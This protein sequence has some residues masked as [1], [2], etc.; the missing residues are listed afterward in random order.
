M[1][2]FSVLIAVLQ[3][4]AVAATAAPFVTV[5]FTNVA[6]GVATSSQGNLSLH[7]DDG[8]RVVPG[9]P[10]GTPY[11][12]LD[13]TAASD[14][15]VDS[16][17]AA[18]KLVGDEMAASFWFRPDRLANCQIAFGFTLLSEANNS[19]APFSFSLNTKENDFGVHKLWALIEGNVD[20]ATN[21]WHHAA[22]LYSISNDTF[23]VW[24]DG[25]PHRNSTIGT[26]E[27]SPVNNFLGL[28]IGRGFKGA[29]ADMR[30][31][32]YS[33]TP[34]EI[35]Q[36]DIS[37]AAR[38]ETADAFLY[39]ASASG[40][41]ASFRKW[42]T[43]MAA[44]A[45]GFAE[46]G[47]VREWMRLQDALWKL[48]E[49]G[50]LAATTS[51]PTLAETPF[52]PIGIYA[53]FEKKRLPFRMPEDGKTLNALAMR[54]ALGEIEGASFM[55]YPYES[56]QFFAEPTVLHGPG[57]ATIPASAIDIRTVKFW[58]S[59]ASGWL[60][61]FGGGKEKPVLTGEILLHDDAMLKVDREKH[62]NYL[63]LSYPDGVRYADMSTYGSAVGMEVFMIGA[64]PV[65]DAPS[66]VPMPFR[67]GDLSQMWITA[68][69]P[70]DATPGDYEGSLSFTLDGKPAG[71]LPLKLHVHPFRLPRA[72]PRYNIDQRLITTWF[73]HI[74]LGTKLSRGG[75]Y[76]GGNSL[77]NACRRLFAECKNMA[78]HNMY[79]PFTSCYASEETE[80]IQDLQFEI[81]SKAGLDLD[82]IMGGDLPSY[83][84]EWVVGMSR[85]RSEYDN[86][87]SV[88]D[89]PKLFAERM[90]AY[91]NQVR[92]GMAR[93][94]AR[95][96]NVT[97]YSYG[98]DEGS[99][100]T[101]RREM[102]FFATLQHFGGKAFISFGA[103]EW[104]SHMADLNDIAAHIARTEAHHWHEGGCKVGTYAAPFSGPESPE[105]WR[106]SMGI[107]V[108]MANYDAVS[109]YAWYEAWNVWNNFVVESRYGNFCIVYPTA[110]GVVDTVG[111]E[112]QREG[113]D[114]M[115]YLTLLRR[116][117]REAIRSR[118][119]E[120]R[121]H[122]RLAYA[123]AEMVDPSSDD[124]DVMR[125]EAARRIV[126]LRE[127]LKD[128]DT[129]ALYE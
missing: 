8:V 120:V 15:R 46:K 114:D 67:Q 126:A 100:D 5:D 4:A 9:G 22:F 102:P 85:R 24:I 36:T 101:V 47:D 37:P 21:K 54:G 10:T 42:C 92:N 73:H 20:T 96:G 63:R 121:R 83:D 50:R 77:S 97:L 31:W 27:P 71:S 103:D 59:H 94:R 127:V 129:E 2:Q 58:H 79:N 109:N 17:Q 69:I 38:K 12:Q 80:D 119:R 48:P 28:A 33:A 51:A 113:L 88:E 18:S 98:V 34:D 78:E 90:A 60:S 64:E 76:G 3:A 93:M 52:L 56:G 7:L 81:M 115:R 95:L 128:V 44:R 75:H 61:Y 6:D 108:Y 105:T 91:T 43:A 111:W 40:S 87:I 72:A 116:L 16:R 57:G 122:G 110:D 89:R 82:P 25:F 53:Y 123:W 118:K 29:I 19:E 13:G 26:D 32:N 68:R 107:R 86:K 117:A 49:I 35:M 112:G 66:F 45:D 84:G 11:I 23:M 124:L 65:H 70:A 55:V 99:P 62:R 74:G 30:V 14:I 104:G 125:D 41:Q 106:R 39:A 1:K